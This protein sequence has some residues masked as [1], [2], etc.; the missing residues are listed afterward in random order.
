M[1]RRLLPDPHPDL[2]A[3]LNNL[4]FALESRG[5][6]DGAE[7]A[8]RESLAMNRKLLSEDHP[9]HPEIAR[10]LGNLAFVLYAKGEHDAAIGMLRESL[11]MN[12]RELGAG[13]PNVAD[14]AVNLA[15]WLIDAGEYAEAEQLLDESLSDSNQGARQRPS[16]SG[17]HAD[18]EGDSAVGHTAL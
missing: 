15:Y 18:G 14:V 10:N 2:A 6:Y 13:H 4:A 11:E 12:R 1:K 9:D 17:E 7:K 8:Y 5:D 3:G 16:T